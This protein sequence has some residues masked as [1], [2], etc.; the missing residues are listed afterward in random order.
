MVEATTNNHHQR[1]AKLTKHIRLKVYSYLDHKTTVTRAAC[2]SREEKS[3]LENSAIARE[4]K[5]FDL[6]FSE[7]RP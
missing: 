5:S 7:S 2:L 1:D 4:G 3:A 6:D